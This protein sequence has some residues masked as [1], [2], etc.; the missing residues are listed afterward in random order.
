MPRGHPFTLKIS[1]RKCGGGRE[2]GREGE[3]RK[4]FHDVDHQ[5][6]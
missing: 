6:R 5:S 2:G 1:E 4:S 3:K